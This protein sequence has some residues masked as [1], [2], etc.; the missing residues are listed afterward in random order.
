MHIPSP[1]RRRFLFAHSS[2]PAS[3]TCKK[4]KGGG[5][6][7]SNA[8]SGKHRFCELCLPAQDYFDCL[9]TMSASCVPGALALEIVRLFVSG[10][11]SELSCPTPALLTS[12]GPE[13]SHG[14]HAQGHVVPRQLSP[15]LELLAPLP[16][17]FRPGARI[18]R[19]TFCGSHCECTVEAATTCRQRNNDKI[20]RRRFDGTI[21]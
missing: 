18:F 17:R 8:D 1:I 21:S 13:D 19:R 12:T 4:S 7:S 20:Q 10:C 14:G 5:S 2:L 11:C 6:K 16:R 3:Q 15:H 9:K